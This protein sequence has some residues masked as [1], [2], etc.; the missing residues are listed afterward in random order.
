M[1]DGW[2]KKKFMENHKSGNGLQFKDAFGVY[3]TDSINTFY[4][5]YYKIW[6]DLQYPIN[7]LMLKHDWP[8]ASLRSED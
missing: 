7:A 8:I 6:V 4:V 1:T 2:L 5:S 3:I